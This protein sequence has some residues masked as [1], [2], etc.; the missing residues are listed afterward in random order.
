MPP[1]GWSSSKHRKPC[2]S[3]YTEQRAYD[4][5]PYESNAFRQSQ[6]ARI[7]AVAHL[8]GLS[9]PDVRTA[10][11]LELGCASGGN[12]IPLAVHSPDAQF[13]GL[14]ISGIQISDGQRLAQELGLVNI[15]LRHAG[16]ESLTLADGKFDYII[17]H[18]VYSW[19]PDSVRDAI[20]RV[21]DQNLADDGV[22]FVSYNTLPGW[23]FV[24]PMRD[25]MLQWTTGIAEPQEKVRVALELLD[26]M[27][28]IAEPVMRGVLQ[29][30]TAS[31][32]S[33]AISYVLH[34]HLEQINSPCYLKDFVA[35]AQ[36]HALTYLSDIEFRVDNPLNMTPLL[37]GLVD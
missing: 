35:H 36:S 25:L 17:C 10:R 6:P 20:L 32:K 14:D 31:L 2:V 18:G 3:E 27:K 4:E 22:A 9:P 8:F 5:V 12:L 28:D 21:C 23:H 34:D 24:Q 16:I 11:V 19:V 37:T 26:D 30:E 29:E 7:A 13:L 15:E 1:L 33:S